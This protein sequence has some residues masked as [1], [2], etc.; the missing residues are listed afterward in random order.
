M[1]SALPSP[2][3]VSLGRCRPAFSH[4][5][6]KNILTAVGTVKIADSENAD[7]ERD[8]GENQD[9]EHTEQTPPRMNSLNRVADHDITYFSRELN[10]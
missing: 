6:C 7:W 5:I 9:S 3:R 2:H 1:M 4:Q 8:P 10:G